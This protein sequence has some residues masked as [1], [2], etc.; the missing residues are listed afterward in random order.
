MRTEGQVPSLVFHPQHNLDLDLWGGLPLRSQWNR[1]K[2]L[3][4]GVG[5]RWTD[6]ARILGVSTRTLSR[7]RQGLGMSVGHDS[8]FCQ[9]SDAPLDDSVR[10]ILTSAPQV[11][12]GL[13]RGAL[14]S[15]GVE[16]T[17]TSDYCSFAK[18]RSSD[19]CPETN[20]ANNPYNIQCS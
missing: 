8:N 5:F 15:R 6:I 10:E 18:I 3:R 12:I 19:V 20:K 11:G 4:E 17:E 7:R 14:K 9:I 16:D 2:H 13:I 1:F